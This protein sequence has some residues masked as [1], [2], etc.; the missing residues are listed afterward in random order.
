MVYGTHMDNNINGIS[1]VIIIILLVMREGYYISKVKE[2]ILISQDMMNQGFHK[3]NKSFFL[4][5]FI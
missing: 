5:W 3:R 1:N 2:E 4:P